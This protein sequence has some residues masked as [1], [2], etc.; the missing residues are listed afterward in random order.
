MSAHKMNLYR[1]L[2]LHLPFKL[3]ERREKVNVMK[4]EECR[5]D[6]HDTRKLRRKTGLRRGAKPPEH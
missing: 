5:L 2:S 4:E 3:S 1:R 6:E